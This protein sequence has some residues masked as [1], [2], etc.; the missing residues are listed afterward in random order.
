[1]KHTCYPEPGTPP[2]RALTAKQARFVEEYLIDL[3]ATQA[4]VRAGYS[5]RTAASIGNENLRKPEISV[6]IAEAQKARS[7]RTGITADR[8]LQELSRVA[9]S[10]IREVLSW[11]PDWV[12]IKPSEGL[13]EDAAAA[14]LR[15]TQTRH[16]T[17][18]VKLHSK[19]TA[20]EILARHLGL[21]AQADPETR[22]AR[23]SEPQTTAAMRADF[24][25]FLRTAL[26]ESERSSP[27]GSESKPTGAD[28][29][30]LTL[31]WWND[32]GDP[33]PRDGGESQ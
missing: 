28:K 19:L 15:V 7:V 2:T 29:V 8:V 16:G 3:S 12:K 17:I 9:F 4:A 24:Q 13:S 1:M 14:I 27:L 22:P 5:A 21:H 23:Y 33:S 32:N 11:G 26:E 31:P 25:D 20:L 18:R 30:A 6:A 10:D